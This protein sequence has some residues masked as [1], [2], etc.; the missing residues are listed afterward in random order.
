M[1]DV[2]SH[3]KSLERSNHSL[4]RPDRPREFTL[5]G[6]RWDL[7][8]QVFAPLYSP[9]TRTGAELLG[10]TGGES[11]APPSSLLEIGCGT[12]VIAV[13]AALLGC[14]SVVATDINEYAVENTR[15]NAERHRVADR[16]TV[17]H[18]DLFSAL[19]PNARFD[20]VFWSSNYVR[21][22]SDYA[23]RTV[24]ERAYVDAGYRTHRG[25][26]SEAVR[27]LTDEGT[28][29]LHFSDRGDLAALRGI[30][31]ECGRELRT[32]RTRTVDEGND[33]VEHLLLEIRPARDRRARTGTG[34]DLVGA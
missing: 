31:A 24:H 9:S 12:G 21:A 27:H 28:A 19:D 11:S 4:T 25:Y 30:A 20:R 32:L 29:L 22:P 3:L 23:Y 8:D 14:T 26:L 2:R 6:R 33:R 13:Q 5:L 18:S 10:L 7:L 16:V 34:G 17:L 1:S 15:L